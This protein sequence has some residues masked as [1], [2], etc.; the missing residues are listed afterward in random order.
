MG[1]SVLH[2]LLC[3]PGLEKD[4]VCLGHSGCKMDRVIP[5]FPMKLKGSDED[6]ERAGCRELRPGVARRP[7]FL[8]PGAQEATLLSVRET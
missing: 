4:F 2:N 6:A 7:P 8:L 1:Q 3:G 5:A